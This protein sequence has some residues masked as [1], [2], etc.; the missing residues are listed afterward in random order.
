MVCA[1][2]LIFAGIVVSASTLG[3]GVNPLPRQ[4]SVTDVTGTSSRGTTTPTINLGQFPMIG[5]VPQ[6]SLFMLTQPEGSSVSPS[7][8]PRGT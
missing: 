3:P 8:N 2:V 6:I 5:P 4:H 7:A 1:L